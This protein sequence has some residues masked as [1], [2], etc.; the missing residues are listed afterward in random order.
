MTLDGISDSELL[1]IVE[2]LAN[3]DGWT[4]TLDVRMQL[5]EN[6]EGPGRSGVGPRLSWLKRYGWLKQHQ[7]DRRLWQL[8]AAGHALLDNP[9]I[10]TA[11]ERAMS[12][13]G[14]AQWLALTRELGQA[15]FAQPLE[16]RTALRRQWHRSLIRGR[17]GSRG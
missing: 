17:V 9:R 6:V 3:E 15:G 7:D 2:D 4:H 14:P 1:A 12:G 5:G 13:F 8:S 10:G 16:V 11:V